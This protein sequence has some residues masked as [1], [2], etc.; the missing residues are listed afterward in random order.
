MSN[1][2]VDIDHIDPRWEEG[3]DYQLVCGLDCPLNFR[4][5]EESENQRKSNR[6]LPWKWSREEIGVI[7]EDPGDLALFLDPDTN[8]WVLEEFLSP[9]WYEKTWRNCG[10]CLGLKNALINDPDIHKKTFRKLIEKNPNHQKEAFAKLL[11]N[12]PNHQSEAGRIGGKKI[13]EEKDETGKS[14]RA[15]QLGKMGCREKKRKSSKER[16]ARGEGLAAMTFEEKSNR[17]KKAISRKYIDPLHP[18]LG[19]HSAPTLALKQKSKG[20]PHGPET[21]VRVE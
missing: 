9:W 8:E 12:N 13:H 4:E 10:P 3:R 7:P 2:G 20:Y 18:D 11:E 17:S 6:F 14:I 5:I 19:A 15:Q 21:R 1:N 16:Y